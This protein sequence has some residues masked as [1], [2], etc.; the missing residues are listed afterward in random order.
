MESLAYAARESVA[1]HDPVGV[2][3][4]VLQATAE[5]AARG[6]LDVVSVLIAASTGGDVRACYIGV[7]AGK[8][9]APLAVVDEPTPPALGELDDRI[10]DDAGRFPLSSAQS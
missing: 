5:S 9:E 7:G 6:D 1:E 2:V 10:T 8:R 4:L 3:G